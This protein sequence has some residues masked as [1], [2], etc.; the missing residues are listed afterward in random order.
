MIR[1]DGSLQY[2]CTLSHLT[3]YLHALD[4][5]EK[6][7]FNDGPILVLEDDSKLDL[8]FMEKANSVIKW[9]TY[10]DP[11]WGLLGFGYSNA[12]NYF[13]NDIKSDVLA[14]RVNRYSYTHAYVLRSA[15]MLKLFLQI[16]NIPNVPVIDIMWH[17]LTRYWITPLH[18]YVYSK[19]DMAIQYRESV[20]EFTSDVR[21]Y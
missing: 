12:Q 2:I 3:T 21:V 14:I 6:G 16:G 11:N 10:T 18:A 17:P 1:L 15:S 5:I 9:L 8:H 13:F 20:G 4:N 19:N 7:L